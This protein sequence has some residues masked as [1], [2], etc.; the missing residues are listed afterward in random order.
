MCNEIFRHTLFVCGN[1]LFIK[2]MVC[3]RG[4][5]RG[6]YVNCDVDR[7]LMVNW[8]TTSPPLVDEKV[9][10]LLRFSSFYLDFVNGKVGKSL[11]GKVI[12]VSG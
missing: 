3:F 10:N 1:V 6:V 9:Y 7:C 2:K 12:E 8:D 4:N 5:G 11:E